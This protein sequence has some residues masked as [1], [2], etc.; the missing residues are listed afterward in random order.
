MFGY[1]QDMQCS[2]SCV[3]VV[4]FSFVSVLAAN[5]DIKANQ[6]FDHFE[7]GRFTAG[8]LDKLC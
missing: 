5:I 2:A 1:T 6:Q 3:L 4:G 8:F 7:I